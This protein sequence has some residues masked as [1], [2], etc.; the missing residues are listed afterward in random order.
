MRRHGFARLEAAVLA[1]IGEVWAHET[2]RAGPQLARRLRGKQQGQHL[3]VRPVEAA[4]E[5]DIEALRSGHKPQIGLAVGEAPVLDFNDVGVDHRG[6][7]P[8]EKL[9]SRHDDQHCLA[10]GSLTPMMFGFACR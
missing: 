3:V 7:A 1:H 4:Q 2:D 6:Q 8:A 10:H 9:V 5:G